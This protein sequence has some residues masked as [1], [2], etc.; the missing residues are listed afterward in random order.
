MN[1]QPSNFAGMETAAVP[2]WQCRLWPDKS[3][4]PVS[5]FYVW[6]HRLRIPL[7]NVIAA[8]AG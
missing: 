6:E 2:K 7:I 5:N 8:G 1:L 3:A 4:G